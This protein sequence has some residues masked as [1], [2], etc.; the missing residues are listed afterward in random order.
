MYKSCVCYSDIYNVMITKI[1]IF[2]YISWLPEAQTPIQPEFHMVLFHSHPNFHLAG[3]SH[4]DVG[5][6]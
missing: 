6:G 5:L 3:W 4:A 2:Q 1:Y